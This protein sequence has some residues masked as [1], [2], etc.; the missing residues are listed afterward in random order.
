MSNQD[1]PAGY[2][3]D[4][5]GRLV[6]EHLVKPL[7]SLM[8]QAVRALIG[9]AE[10]LSAQ[11]AR[12]RG[13]S[14]DDIASF[15]SIAADQYGAKIGGAKGNITLT[16][17]DGTLKVQVAVA[18]RLTFGP[19]LQVAKALIDECI[20]DWSKGARDE[21]CALVEH[22]F[23]P[24]KEGQVSPDAVL[25]LRRVEIGDD[26][27]QRA[28]EAITDSIRIV[29]SKSYIRFYRRANAQAPWQ[30][31]TVDLASA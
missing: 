12:F 23:R 14:F 9:H 28:M 13:H 10:A 6:P 1:T 24:D 20:V 31:I 5:K 27:W 11:I 26:R 7:D 15:L 22:A 21:I 25:A 3:R 2:M 17:Y 29:G 30:A 8:D 18:D 19:E 16:S 4:A